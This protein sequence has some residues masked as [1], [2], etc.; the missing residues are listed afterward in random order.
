MIGDFFYEAWYLSLRTLRRFFRVPA[1]WIGIIFFPLIQLFVFSQLFKDIIQLP[2]FRSSGSGSYLAYLAPGQIAFT[3]FFAVA[4]S[5]SAILVEYRNGYM[6]KLRATPI[7][8]V[9]ILVGELAPLFIE[10]A[11][12]AGGIL[13]LSV[14]ARPPDQERA[15]HWHAFARLFSNRLHVDRVCAAGVDA[16]LAADRE[17]L[18]S[19]HIPDRSDSS[20]HGERL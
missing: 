2:G 5:G 12:M 16:R 10:S 8:R 1:N 15:G 11:I 19:D 18:E 20:P 3:A 7:F 17:Q 13:L 14:R 9:S 4:W 6:D